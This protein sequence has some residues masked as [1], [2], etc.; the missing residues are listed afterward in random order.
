MDRIP[1]L[2]LPNCLRLRNADAELIVSTDVGPRVL[3]Y[4]LTGGENAFG[5][6]PDK[7][8]ET[9]L[10]A[11]KPYAGQRLWASPELFPATYA[12]DNSPIAHRPTS[13]L[14]LEL[15]QSQDAAGL[16]K[17]MTITLA[18]H[19]PG[20]EITYSI[21]NRNLWPIAIAPWSI[22]ALNRGVA[23]LPREPFRS[24]DQT[25]SVAQPL[26]LFFFTDLQDS[27]YT[28]GQK[29]ILL[30]AD[31]QHTAA[32]KI[33]I[34]NKRGWCA[35]LCET[36]L[37]MKRFTYDPAAIYPDDGANNEAYVAGA[38]MELE[39]LGPVE[40][41]QPGETASFRESWQ[42]F[43]GSSADFN[44]EDAVHAALAPHL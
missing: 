10:G 19:G 37:L 31:A 27:R 28:L 32:Q 6:Y 30:R 1:Y 42:L 14:S 3:R 15:E 36:S 43:P 7:A 17:Q 20:V 38:Y 24:H 2:G 18:E 9:S 34:C 41:L 11:W 4:A 22:V 23:V 26:S 35:H 5:E 39:L 8:T 25:V 13:E 40:T 21:T 12:P 29:Y 44:S 33:G 16:V